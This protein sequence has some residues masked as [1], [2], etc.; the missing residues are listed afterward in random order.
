M[1]CRYGHFDYVGRFMQLFVLSLNLFIRQRDSYCNVLFGGVVYGVIPVVWTDDAVFASY[2]IEG[3]EQFKIF[4]KFFFNAG[5]IAVVALVALGVGEYGFVSER[6]RDCMGLL[7]ECSGRDALQAV[8]ANAFVLILFSDV[9]CTPVV[10]GIDVIAVFNLVLDFQKVAQGVFR[11]R[12][13]PDY[14]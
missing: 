5:T 14:Q 1:P 9:D 10:V 2:G 3:A 7:S 13:I 11:I 6:F 12:V 8:T 4:R